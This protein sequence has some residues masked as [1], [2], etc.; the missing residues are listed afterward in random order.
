MIGLD[1]IAKEFHMSLTDIANILGVTRKSISNWTKGW[2]SIPK[3]H[4]GKLSLYFDIPEH[5]FQ[6]ELDDAEKLEIQLIKIKR[7]KLTD[8]TSLIIKLNEEIEI[9]KLFHFLKD[10]AQESEEHYEILQGIKDAFKRNNPSYNRAVLVFISLLKNSSVWE[11]DSFYGI[12]EIK[13]AEDLHQVL[14]K[15]NVI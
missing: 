7:A 5:Y 14:R 6:K 9:E 3:K 15:H 8:D 10:Q 1:Y 11:G 4:L 12:K 2:Q 13:L